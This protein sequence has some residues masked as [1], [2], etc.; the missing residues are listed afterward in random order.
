MVGHSQGGDEVVGVASDNPEV[1][2]D[3]LLTLDISSHGINNTKITSNVVEAKNYFQTS[4][5]LGGTKI[6]TSDGN[7]TTKLTNVKATNTT[8]MTI[9]NDYRYNVLNEVKKVIPTKK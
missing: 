2:I 1:K 8:H 9:D 3:K 6:S 5:I 4:G 7:T